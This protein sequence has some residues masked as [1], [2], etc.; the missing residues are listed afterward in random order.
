MDRINWPNFDADDFTRFCNSLLSLEVSKSFVPFSA[1]GRDG[2]VDGYF[3]GA[4]NN[5]HGK[6]RFQYKFYKVDRKTGVNKIKSQIKEE[7]EKISDELNFVLLTN[8]EFLPQERDQII[9]LAKNYL[10]ELNKP[11]VSFEIWDGAKIHTLYLQFP[12]LKFWLEEGVSTAQLVDYKEYFHDRLISD[13]NHTDT[14]NNEFI[15][16][17]EPMKQLTDFI[18]SDDKEMAVIFGEAGIGKTRLAVEFFKTVLKPN[19]DWQVLVLNSYTINFDKLTASITNRKNIVI[20][21]DDAHKYPQ[22]VIADMKRLATNSANKKVK[23]IL[24]VRSI[25]L[26][27]SLRYIRALEDDDITEVKLERLTIKDTKDLFLKL[28]LSN[29]YKEY[30]DQLT[31]LSSGRPILIV[32]LLRAISKGVPIPTIK[33]TG[34]LRKYVLDYINSIV[35]ASSNYSKESEL[36]IELLIKIVCLIEPIKYN[37][38][39][40]IES[41]AISQGLSIEL[42]KHIFK[43]L[44]D[45]NLAQGRY[46]FS[47]TPDY[48]SDIYLTGTDNKLIIDSIRSFPSLIPNIIKNLASV[49]EVYSDSTNK[50]SLL[51]DILSLYIDRFKEGSMVDAL[52]ILNTIERIT[53]NKPAFAVKAINQYIEKISETDLNH[54]K[55]NLIQ[56]SN[57]R[58]SLGDSIVSSLARILHDLM[59]HNDRFE[60]VFD[61]VRLIYR[62]SPDLTLLNNTFY[63]TKRDFINNY[64][65]APQYYFLKKTDEVI[66]AKS[67]I[68]IPFVVDGLRQLLKL[69]F[70]N[71]YSDIINIATINITTYYIPSTSAVF[72]L[73]K[74]V[75][76]SLIRIYFLDFA[77]SELREKIVEELIDIPRSISASKRNKLP[78]TGTNEIQIVFDF[79]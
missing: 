44:I 41:L 67:A 38:A 33:E 31:V 4:Y 26:H 71:T 11:D 53:Y 78:Y 19:D 51:D 65:L 60:F 18:N 25:L 1:P 61:T 2:G 24:T 21:V 56:A 32:E 27:E 42:I 73:R 48:Y 10:H 30:V 69:E 6:W 35:K 57:N 9:E 16:R 75:V 59:Y 45:E 55:S 15:A 13:I 28:L 7:I 23:I 68:D 58:T 72:N 20:M 62:V 49:D 29:Y 14:L 50:V 3:D 40:I 70:E 66:A 43:Q 36:K 12:I 8:V 46:E 34:F 74:E 39:A 54:F 5:Q 52:E 17:E 37:D 79:L 76:N 63:F 22:Q 64:Q 47:I 77:N